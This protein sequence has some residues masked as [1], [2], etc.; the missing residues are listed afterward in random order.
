MTK[1]PTLHLCG[2]LALSLFACDASEGDGKTV[3]KADAKAGKADTKAGKADAK[4]TAKPDAKATPD[5]K[6]APDAKAEPD[7]KADDGAGPPDADA[8][9][10]DVAKLAEL[11]RA[12][13]ADPAAADDLLEKA[14]M[15]RAQFEAAMVAIAKDEWQTDLYLAA[16]T[17]PKGT[18]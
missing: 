5:A 4:A 17:A 14:G 11:A 7:A 10:P 6:A 1:H 9:G 16:L 8:A 13:S 15:D 2:L 3:A 12:I 18:G